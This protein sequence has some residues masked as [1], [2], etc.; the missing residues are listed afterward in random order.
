[1]VYKGVIIEESLE[2]KGIL[3][4]FK[5]IKTRT[6]KV[7]VSHKTPWLRQWTLHV[8]EI[9]DDEAEE[10]AQLLSR[11]IDHT[12]NHSWYVDYLNDAMHY[13]IFPGKIFRVNR[14]RPA[15]YEAVRAYG[16]KLGIPDYQLDFS[17][18]EI[19]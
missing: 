2:D 12:H 7:A 10:K 15:E 17:F 13:I 5:V 1:M 19:K 9:P 18:R 6:E 11:S 14:S 3:R 8:V 16:I 4:Q